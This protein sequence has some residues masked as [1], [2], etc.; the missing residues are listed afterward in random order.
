MI[1]WSHN[2]THLLLPSVGGRLFVRTV[3]SLLAWETF[4]AFWTIDLET[5][6]LEGTDPYRF[7]LHSVKLLS[8]VFCELFP[9]QICSS[10]SPPASFRICVLLPNRLK[11]EWFLLNYQFLL[12]HYR[13]QVPINTDRQ[14]R[15]HLILRHHCFLGCPVIDLIGPYILPYFNFPRIDMSFVQIHLPQLSFPFML[16]VLSLNFLLSL[17]HKPFRFFWL[18]CNDQIFSQHNISQAT[19]WLV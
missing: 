12:H 6:G 13:F 11:G 15:N 19:S 5:N 14:W 10:F 2:S 1:V 7:I 17:F 16:L 9:F 4:D 3:S 18:G 8:L